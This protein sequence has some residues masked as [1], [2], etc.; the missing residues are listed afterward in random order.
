VEG[1]R[2]IIA[3]AVVHETLALPMKIMVMRDDGVSRFGDELG[4]GQPQRQADRNGEGVST[5][6]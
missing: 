3:H 2:K 1:C 6:G 4:D 5:I